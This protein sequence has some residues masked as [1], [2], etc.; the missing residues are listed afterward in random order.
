MCFK[1]KWES[2]ENDV[3]CHSKRSSPQICTTF[4]LETRS[5]YFYKIV[6]FESILKEQATLQ[7]MSS[8]DVMIALRFWHCIESFK[9]SHSLL[10]TFP[11]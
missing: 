7:D 9:A 11:N 5:F 10:Y 8:I 1:E 6:T 3:G 4:C 2:Q